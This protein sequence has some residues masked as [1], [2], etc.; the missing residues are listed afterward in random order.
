MS[1]CFGK[2]VE[3]IVLSHIRLAVMSQGSDIIIAAQPH[4]CSPMY[5]IVK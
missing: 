5:P 3:N 4:Y 2:I 1:Y